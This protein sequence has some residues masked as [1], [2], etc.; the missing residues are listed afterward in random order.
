MNDQA[1]YNELAKENGN[2]GITLA[3]GNVALEFNSKTRE[4]TGR[5]IDAVAAKTKTLATD[6]Y[7][8]KKIFAFQTTYAE[9]LEQ[10]MSEYNDNPLKFCRW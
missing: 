5:R 7:L 3:C 2:F 6:L 1:I 10:I 9:A 4:I 8:L